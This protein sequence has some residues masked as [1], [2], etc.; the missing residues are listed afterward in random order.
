MAA[1]ERGNC[2]MIEYLLQHGAQINAQDENGCTPLMYAASISGTDKRLE[3]VKFL[4]QH[5][6]DLAI[7]NNAGQTVLMVHAICGSVDVFNYL[8][9]DHKLK[10][11]LPT[12]IKCISTEKVSLGGSYSGYFTIPLLEYCIKELDLTTQTHPTI[13][14]DLVIF[15][16]KRHRIDIVKRLCQKDC[17]FDINIQDENGCNVLMHLCDGESNNSDIIKKIIDELQPNIHAKNKDGKRLFDIAAQYG[18]SFI[19]TYFIDNHGFTIDTPD[20]NGFTPLLHAAARC[21]LST[22]ETLTK[23]M[24]IKANINATD[25][26]GRTALML[27]AGAH[28]VGTKCLASE[29]N[30]NKPKP[31]WGF[32]SKSHLNVIQFLIEQGCDVKAVDNNE[33][34]ALDYAKLAGRQEIIEYLTT[35]KDTNSGKDQDTYLDL[36][37]DDN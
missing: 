1:A 33:H 36:L 9:A 24:K 19:L 26:Q 27:A 34:T 11:D 6:A 12:L 14:W 10:I 23:Y 22:L 35:G 31:R 16:A 28:L 7:T 30:P 4:L 37:G 21:D 18:D 2:D 8:I 5:K 25:N 20:C 32:R 13:V 3:T 17:G 29:C 15:A